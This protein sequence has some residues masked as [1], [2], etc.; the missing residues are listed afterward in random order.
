MAVSICDDHLRI[1]RGL[2]DALSPESASIFADM[3]LVLAADFLRL[4]VVL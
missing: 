2:V 3:G 4:G 1:G